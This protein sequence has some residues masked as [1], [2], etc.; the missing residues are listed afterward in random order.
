MNKNLINNINNN[1]K[2]LKNIKKKK[3]I[4]TMKK[5]KPS[6][7]SSKSSALSVVKTHKNEPL[8]V[9]STI[10]KDNPVYKYQKDGSVL[11]T[12]TELLFSVTTATTNNNVANGLNIYSLPV[13]AGLKSTFP[14]LSSLASNYVSYD[15]L[16]LSFGFVSRSNMTNSGLVMFMAEYDPSKGP[17]E[18]RIELLN[19]KGVES[20]VFKNLAYLLNPKDMKKEKSH[21]IR[22]GKL[23]N[24]QDI[25]LYDTCTLYFGYEGTPSNTT[26]GD[27]VVKYNVR[28][29]TPYLRLSEKQVSTIES[30]MGTSSGTVTQQQ[31]YGPAMG[32]ANFIGD[33]VGS[34]LY[35]AANTATGGVL[36][37]LISTGKSIF[38]WITQTTVSSNG[39][40]PDSYA[41]SVRV[42]NTNS[43]NYMGGSN[44]ISGNINFISE[45]D[46]DLVAKGYSYANYSDFNNDYTDISS[47]N[48]VLI[49]DSVVLVSGIMNRYKTYAC[50]VPANAIIQ[51]YNYDNSSIL[52]VSASV[53]MTD[54]DAR[55]IGLLGNVLYMGDL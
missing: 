7:N 17:P 53:T 11:F 19:R 36:G 41:V 29:S 9:S 2:K 8:V 3:I 30:T 31:P 34:L 54:F 49:S 24:S 12:N 23:M 26:I 33:F 38:K 28:L 51:L 37:Q 48:A 22:L 52:P 1:N 47:T 40:I 39:S 42:P 4:V 43:N 32:V 50:A 5:H 27:I 21:Y 14:F 13:N 35:T 16:S 45:D 20:Q 44:F 15:F 10:K 6:I 25:K 55:K 46:K 18:N